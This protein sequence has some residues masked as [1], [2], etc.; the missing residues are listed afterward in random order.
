LFFSSDNELVI[1]N[2][3][4]TT[5]YRFNIS[6]K[7]DV[8]VGRHYEMSVTTTEISKIQQYVGE[9]KVDVKPWKCYHNI[10]ESEIP[11]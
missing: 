10:T 11:S 9:D 8:G 6:A 3:K 2:L 7:N 1:E 5:T 4:P